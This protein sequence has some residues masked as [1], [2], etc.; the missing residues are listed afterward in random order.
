MDDVPRKSGRLRRCLKVVAAVVLAV[1]VA[2]VVLTP[3]LL[4]HIPVPPL[5][6]DLSP[7]LSGKAAELF[8][9]KRATANVE[10][11]RG[12]RDGFLVTSKGMVLGWPYSATAHVRFGFVRVEGEVAL[13]FD[14]TD[15]KACADFSARSAD[16]WR[17]SAHIPERR[18]TQDDAVLASIVSEALPPSI[19]NL[20]FSGAFKLDADGDCTPSRPVPAWNVRGAL[21]DVDVSFDADG[22][23]AIVDGL[24]L[25]FGASGIADHC[26]IAPLFPRAD[27]V[28]FAGFTLSNV[29]ACVRATESSYLVTEAGARCCG[30]EL[31]LYSLFLDPNSLSMGATIFIDGMDAHEILSH[32]S[33][34]RGYAS[35]R[36][37][38]K[39]P[40]FL[41][42]GKS[43]RFR[44]AHLFSTPG[45][46]GVVRVSDST[47]ILEN[48]ALGGVPEDMRDNISK[49]LRNL[50][51]TALKIELKQGEKGEGSSLEL[52]LEGSATHG[53]TTVPVSLDV[54]FHGDIDQLVNTGMKIKRR[55]ER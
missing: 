7:Y 27:A 15:W 48:L 34:F 3:F 19:S 53:K 41:K 17:F 18:V 6:F 40:F 49:A 16:D 45:E 33:G 50:D 21:D 23:L 9:D 8:A 14:G 11:R 55:N 5:E 2:L 1:V 22:G 35:G 42:D 4:T 12:R 29:F 20:V 13:T 10:I 32:V 39:L 25:R 36:L 47:P 46:T 51:Y 43:I 31:K 44:N 54:T 37:H 26:D 28:G 24:R 30:G 38:G 52:V